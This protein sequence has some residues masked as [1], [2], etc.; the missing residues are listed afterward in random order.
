[1]KIYNQSKN[2]ILENPNLEIGYLSED[3]IIVDIIK[4]QAEQKE[5]FHYEF[6][7]YYDD[8]GHIIGADRIKIIDKEYIPEIPDRPIYEDIMIYNQFTYKEYIIKKIRERYSIDDEIAIL[9]QKDSKYSE[10]QEYFNYVEQCKSK[11]KQFNLV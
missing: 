9:R 5:E 1:M 2:K 4:G 8:K 10:Y 3:K 11:A 7:N 6:K